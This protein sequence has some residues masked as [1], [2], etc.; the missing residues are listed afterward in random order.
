MQPYIYSKRRDGL[1]RPYVIYMDD[2]ISAFLSMFSF[3]KEIL[4]IMYCI[5]TKRILQ[6]NVIQ[7][8]VNTAKTSI[9]DV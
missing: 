1:E 3:L 5:Y 4:R 9:P 2:V 7:R 6:E 8:E